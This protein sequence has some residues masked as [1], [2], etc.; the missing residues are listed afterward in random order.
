[1]SWEKADLTSAMTIVIP[2]TQGLSLMCQELVKHFIYTISFNQCTTSP[3]LTRMRKPRI[4]DLG[5]F[6]DNLWQSQNLTLFS[7]TFNSYAR[8]NIFWIINTFESLKKV[9]NL[10]P[11][12]NTPKYKIQHTILGSPGDGR[13]DGLHSLA[14]TAGTAVNSPVRTSFYVFT[15]NLLNSING[16]SPV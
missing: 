11:G 6:M 15:W 7:L 1:M 13:L 2:A 4:R 8:N 14:I 5:N 10:L 12:K 16:P 9:I 3:V